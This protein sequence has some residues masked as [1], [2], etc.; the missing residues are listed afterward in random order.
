MSEWSA[1]VPVRGW[2]MGKSRLGIPG[3]ARAMALDTASALRGCAQIGEVLVV[4]GDPEV[5]RDME[6]IGCTGVEESSAGSLNG[7][8]AM[9]AERRSHEGC[10]V[11][12]GDLPALRP[13][14]VAL[15]LQRS[16]REPCFI[17]DAQG[18][19]STIWMTRSG[20]VE[21]HFGERSRARHRF[22]GVIELARLPEEDPEAWARL[23]R[24][25]D[26]GVDLSDAERLGL[27]THTSAAIADRT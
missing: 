21:T 25:V 20:R 13:A 17:A 23:R 27:G 24:D 26:D 18:T 6:H 9:A 11:V 7:A 1:V 22:H 10:I 15:A 2:T 4:S 14:D 3:V 5:R 12:L 16:T 8:I 19:G